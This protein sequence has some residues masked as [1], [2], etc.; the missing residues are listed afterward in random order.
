MP[1]LPLQSEAEP[2]AAHAVSRPPWLFTRKI[3]GTP[4][5]HIDDPLQHRRIVTAVGAELQHP[6]HLTGAKAGENVL[7]HC[8]LF[9]PDQCTLA[10][11]SSSSA[12]ITTAQRATAEALSRCRTSSR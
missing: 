4:Q 10:S 6:T 11:C 1:Q 3:N 7:K 8:L 2:A 12:L 5:H 9:Q